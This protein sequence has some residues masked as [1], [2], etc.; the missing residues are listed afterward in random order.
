M[1][2][3]IYARKSTEQTGVADE[4]K[5]VTRQIENA[6]AFATARGWTVDET[7]I[8]VDDGISG[9]E[10]ERRPGFSRLMA[11]AASSAAFQVLIVS[12]QKSLGRESMET[13]YVLK[14]L[15]K[16]GVDVWSYLETRCLTPRNWMDKVMSSVRAGADEAHKEDTSRRNHEKARRQILQGHVAGGQCFGYRNVDVTAPGPDG[17]PKRQHVLR[18]IDTAQAAVIRRIFELAAAGAGIKTIAKTLNA[19]RALCPRSQQGRPTSWAPSTVREVLH[20]E[21]YRGRLVWNKTRKRD[22]VWGQKHQTDRPASDWLS[23]PAEH[24]RIVSDELWQGVHERLRV[25]REHA[26]AVRRGEALQGTDTRG[27]RRDYLLSG[28]ARCAACAGSMQAVSRG[29][30][31]D[32]RTTTADGRAVRVFR[33]VCGNYVNRGQSVCG[34]ARMASMAIADQAIRGFLADEV[35]RPAVLE[36]ALDQAI[37]ILEADRRGDDRE[38][39]R[40]AVVTRLAALERELENLTDTAARGGAVPVVLEA[41]QRKDRARLELVAELA[42]LERQAAAVPSLK[43]RAL[44]QELRAYLSDWQAMTTQHVRET[45][46]LLDTVLRSRIV[47]EPIDGADGAALYE[48]RLPLHFDRLLAVAVPSL[49]GFAS[50]KD[51]VPNGIRSLPDAVLTCDARLVIPAA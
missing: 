47:F 29:S 38:R 44:R 22:A 51:G 26:L 5:S 37:G 3:A 6:R 48:L 42:T 25:R 12:E 20:R 31:I 28:L 41:L 32:G 27:W 4:Q 13:G 16:A 19:E 18:E 24:L 17:R 2:A 50:G 21:L 1:I 14:R 7:G 34:N 15:A 23:V 39:R 11:T 36:A 49:S 40:T 33:Y 45:R 35:L 8:F 30:T 10:F 43:P 46:A 9:S